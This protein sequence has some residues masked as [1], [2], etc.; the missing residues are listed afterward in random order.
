MKY[1]ILLVLI[2]LLNICYSQ[3]GSVIESTNYI[4][5]YNT[6]M[7]H[8]K[9]IS[10]SNGILLDFSYKYILIRNNHYILIYNENGQYTGYSIPYNKNISVKINNN[11]III[12]DKVYLRFYDFKGKYTGKS[13]KI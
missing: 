13:I 9:S 2:F 4:K 10:L 11:N 5:I 3:I 8:T 6:K 12:S 1:K 7:Q